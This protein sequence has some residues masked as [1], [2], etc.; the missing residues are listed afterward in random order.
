MNPRS[1]HFNCR[2]AF[3][4]IELLVVIGIIG[5]A[6][7][8]IGLALGTGNKGVAL[9]NAQGTLTSALSG[10]RAQAALAQADAA[11][12]VNAELGSDNFLR[13]LRIVVNTRF[14]ATNKWMIRGEP[15][16]LPKGIF[17][18][19]KEGVFDDPAEVD[20]EGDWSSP[21]WKLYSTAYDESEDV[22]LVDEQGSDISAETYHKLYTFDPRGTTAPGKVVISPAEREADGTI[23]FKTPE[24][25]RGAKVSRYG[26]PTFLSEVEA[27]K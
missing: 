8:G 19:P 22:Q 24:F 5:V 13:E 25:V 1:H 27:F 15:I 21:S 11:I 23:Q 14:G 18:V 3:T 16:I 10:A 7:G 9:Q 2:P 4:L 12:F 6:V 17:L 20:F 26:V